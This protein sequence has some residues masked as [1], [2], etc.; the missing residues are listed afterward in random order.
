MHDKT[1]IINETI[2]DINKVIGMSNTGLITSVECSEM[3]AIKLEKFHM[4]ML[5]LE[6]TG[7]RYDEDHMKDLLSI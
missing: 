3:L 1:M 4:R 2:E 5:F 7:N 6:I